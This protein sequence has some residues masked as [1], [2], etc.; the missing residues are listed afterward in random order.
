M[1]RA[2]LAG[3]LLL[4]GCARRTAPAPAGS[5]EAAPPSSST[6]AAAP[7]SKSVHLDAAP[8]AP[9]VID[10]TP[11]NDGPDVALEISR[12]LPSLRY[13]LKT[14]G[15]AEPEVALTFAPPGS[16]NAT[17]L[18]PKPRELG[19]AGRYELTVKGPE[20]HVTMIVFAEGARAPLSIF[21]PPP[22]PA[23]L[24]DRQLLV[25]YPLLLESDLESLPTVEELF[26]SAPPEIFVFSRGKIP[27]GASGPLRNEPLLWA[28][29]TV[30]A[31]DGKRYGATVDDLLAEPDGPI[32]LPRVPRFIAEPD[33]REAAQPTVPD[34]VLEKQAEAVRGMIACTGDT[35]EVTVTPGCAMLE[36][37]ARRMT[38][39]V[40]GLQKRARA[41]ALERA[42]TRLVALFPSKR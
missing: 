27:P 42:R 18:P 11:R 19:R 29:T 1:R 28:R 26:A 2:S 34:E 37:E 30:I 20:V 24:D 5:A 21:A 35:P 22:A 14:I 32:G 33:G 4:A 3:I 13:A 6:I 41:S 23:T 25:R 17:P 40:D 31:A 36:R 12:P 7:N 15:A 10:V 9:L 39:L 16:P 8:D 38:G